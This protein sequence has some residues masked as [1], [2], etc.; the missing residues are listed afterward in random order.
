LKVL[1]D[2]KT[3]KRTKKHTSARRRSKGLNPNGRASCQNE[4][5]KGDI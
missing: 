3:I 4:P 1:D 2:S 5:I